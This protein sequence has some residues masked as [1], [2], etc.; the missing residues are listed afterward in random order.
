M[1]YICVLTVDRSSNSDFHIIGNSKD[2]EKRATPGT[3][4][5]YRRATHNARII[6]DIME[7]VLKRYYFGYGHYV[8]LREHL[9]NV[10]DMT[11]TLVDTLASCSERMTRK[12]II[13][14]I[15]DNIEKIMSPPHQ[16]T[17]A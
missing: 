3:I 15:K 7:V 1:E 6:E 16:S 8:C 4:E 5:I 17:Q 2:I 9:I 12:E 13:Q 14:K 10:I 11:T